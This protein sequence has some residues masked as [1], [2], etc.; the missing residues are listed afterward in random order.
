MI[1]SLSADVPE[2]VIDI[3]IALCGALARHLPAHS[4]RGFEADLRGM[5]GALGRNGDLTAHR[6]ISD[7]AGAVVRNRPELFG[8]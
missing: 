6:L 4:V 2:T 8:H 3:V 5:A 7:F 1:S